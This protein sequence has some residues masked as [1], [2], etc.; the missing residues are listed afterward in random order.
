V[1][2]A[3][4]R[5]AVLSGGAFFDVLADE[6]GAAGAGLAESEEMKTMAGD[7][8]AEFKG[9]DSA[10]LADDLAERRQFGCGFEIE[11]IGIAAAMKLSG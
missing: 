9:G 2:E 1:D 8:E 6:R 7:F 10:R 3:E 11:G 4:V 5:R